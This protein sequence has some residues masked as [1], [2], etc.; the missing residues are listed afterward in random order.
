MNPPIF[1][2]NKIIKT[3]YVIGL[4]FVGVIFAEN[5]TDLYDQPSISTLQVGG[6]YSR[7][8]FKI[9]GES[10]FSG[11]LGG[12]QGSYEYHPHNS[13]YGGLRVAWKQGNTKNSVADRNLAYVD[14]QERVGY[15]YASC[16]SDW[17]LTLFSGFGYRFLGHKLKQH[18]DSSIRFD[19]NEFYIP[20]G[21]LLE[22]VFNSCWS[23]G[24]DCIWMPQVY[25][26]VKITPL[27]GAQWILKESMG[28]VLIELPFTFFLT[29]DKRYALIF[30]PYYE[31]WED[32]RSTA[33][34]SD[35]EKLGLPRN[36]YH[37]WGVELNVAY[38][39]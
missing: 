23:I 21:F 12:I 24:L 1:L 20:V 26:T 14:V 2:S 16:C 5:E 29:H 7:A 38:S 15:T 11:N 13:F 39:F 35:G 37:F 19:Y 18:H 10:S 25:S 28:N 33:K 31:N 27:K 8:N 32:G 36:R 34:T 9:D 17:S 3:F 6:S 30:K 4:L 22:Y